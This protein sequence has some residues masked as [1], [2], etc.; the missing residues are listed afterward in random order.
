MIETIVH[1]DPTSGT[2][3]V[4]LHEGLGSAAQWRELPRAIGEATGHA[5]VAYSRAGYG[6]S[7]P[8]PLPRLLTYMQDEA[9]EGLP[10]LLDDLGIER[11]ILIGHS[12]GASIA[13]VH[14]GLDQGGRI[15]RLVLLAPHVFV[16]DVS[17]RSIAAA[18][19]AYEHGDLRAKLA[20]WHGDNVDVAFWGWNRAWL[21][22]AFRTW[23]I[24]ASLPNIRIPVLVIQG[25][26]DPYGT[27]A[28]VHAIEQQ[29]KGPFEKLI[30]PRCGHAPQRDA[31]DVTRDAI[32]RFILDL[33]RFVTAQNQSLAFIEELRAGKKT[34]HWM[35]FV[36]PQIAG[37]GH[38]PMAQR[39]AI[40]S[41]DEARAYLAHPVLGAR[42]RE[43]VRILLGLPNRDPVA[44]FGSIDAMKLRSSLT[45]FM[46]AAPEEPLFRDALDRYYE[47]SA[48]P[49]TDQKLGTQ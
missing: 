48:D 16:E 33:E 36:F 4:F 43:C 42:L 38:S 5:T 17:V 9:R 41:L 6:K 28:Q 34:S 25:E 24:E 18:R 7:E 19:D 3:L 30:I 37:L 8:V 12:D 35:W 40:A 26:D 46:R 23:N 27:L 45:L 11:A 10:R 31:P 13:I 44:I 20:R 22:P 47:G 29:V 2:T 32:V 49:A 15:E 39:Y 1:G 21:D 14:A